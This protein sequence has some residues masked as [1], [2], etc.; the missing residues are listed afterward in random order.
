MLNG[1]YLSTE[2]TTLDKDFQNLQKHVQSPLFSRALIC[3][4]KSCTCYY[5]QQ[6]NRHN[7]PYLSPSP[8]VTTRLP[9]A[10]SS[11]LKI[12]HTSI[13]FL[14]NSPTQPLAPL[15]AFLHDFPLPATSFTLSV[16]RLLLWLLI[17]WELCDD[18]IIYNLQTITSLLVK[19]FKS[20]PSVFF[21]P[22]CLLTANYYL[23]FFY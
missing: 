6:T 22:R 15:W 4:S 8:M 1:I 19:E 13:Y 9:G 11:P 7:C 23:L 21:L 17:A 12:G 18:L 14:P 16:C 2:T 10:L 20:A 3:R 5:P